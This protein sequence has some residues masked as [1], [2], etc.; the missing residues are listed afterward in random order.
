MAVSVTAIMYA[1]KYGKTGG[2]KTF[3]YS[4]GVL[5]AVL[6]IPGI[7]DIY[8]SVKSQAF[9]K[10][11][12]L[13][14]MSGATI[15][16]ITSEIY[17][18][19]VPS[20]LSDLAK[21]IDPNVRVG[22]KGLAGV[23][24][25]IPFISMVLPTKKNIFGESI[26]GESALSDILFGARVK[27]DKETELI[28]EIGRVSDATGKGITFTNWAKSS[29]KTL[30]QFKEKVGEERFNEVSVEYGEKLKKEL[31][32]AISK[33]AY[34]RLNYEEKLKVLNG[35]DADAMADIFIKYHFRYKHPQTKKI[36]SHI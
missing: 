15:D 24:A 31:E 3:Q 6:N 16:Y 20:F 36:P 4:K 12:S 32:S 14:E 2:E 34:Q 13:E 10:N 8:D 33:P 22:G 7:S 5:A 1:R 21:A 30:A 25:K 18:R 26:K 17:S 9:K 11:Q 28:K 27:T 29:S 35:K 23:T 19:L